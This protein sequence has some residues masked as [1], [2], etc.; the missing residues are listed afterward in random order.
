MPGSAGTLEILVAQAGKALQLLETLL[1]SGNVL[2]L[3]ASLGLRFPPQLLSQTTFTTALSK[4][5]AAAGALPSVLTKLETDISSG[6]DAAILADGVQIVQQIGTVISTLEDI[7]AQLGP[8]GSSLGMNAG[9]VAT[10]G[11]NLATSLLNYTIISYL[12][13]VQPGTVGILNI[14]GLIDYLPS[15]GVAN[16]PVHPP[17]IVRTL[18]LSRLGDL[19]KSP[20]TLAANLFDWGSPGFDGTKLVPRINTSLNL[21]GVGSRLIDT[22]PPNALTSSFVSLQANP[23]TNPPGLL[24]TLAET[25]ADGINLTLPITAMWSVDM[26]VKGTF[27]T[28]LVATVT[29][30]TRVAIKPPSGTL[31]GSLQMNLAAKAPDAN[32]PLILVGETGG[33]YVGADSFS[34]GAGLTVTWDS[35]SGTADPLIQLAVT[36]GVV[37][38]DMSDADGFL[39]DVIGGTP[40]QATFDLTGTWQPD[41]GLHIQ[42]GAQLEI[43]LPLHLDLGPVTL[44]TLYLIGGVSTTGIP[45]EASVALGVALGPIQASV[46]RVGI[47]A[48]LTFP[49]GGGNLGPADLQIKF[50]PPNGLGLDLDMGLAA[51]G[52]YITFDPVKGQYAGVLQV[53]LVD[54]IQVVVIGVLDTIMPDGSSGFSLLLIITFNFPPIQ[55]GFGFT[56]IGVGGL[57]GI[58]RTMSVSALQAGFR[59]DTL[60]LVLSPPD[61][62]ANAPQI[63]SN[64]RNFFP[65]AE[66]RYLFGPLLTLGWGTPTLLSLTLAVL[67]E[68]PDPIRIVILGLIDAGLPTED[69]ALLKLHIE[70]LGVIDFGMQTL[71]IDGSLYDSSLLIY[72]LAGDLAFRLSWG[73]NPNFVFSLGGFNPHFNT[74]GLS[75]PANMQRMSVSIGDGDNPRIS[76]NSYFAITSNSV[77]FGANVQAYAA[78]GGFSIQGYLGFDVL[79]I[80][81]PFSFE[82]DFSAS[83][84]VAYDGATLLGLTVNGSIAGPTPWHLHGEVSI[85]LLFFSVSASVDLTW[86]SS[87]Q[88][89]IPQQPVLPDLFKALQNPA[90]WSAAL[91]AGTGPTVTLTTAKP[92]STMLLVHPM[93]T[94][95]V[96]E[97]VVPLDLPITRYGNATPSDGTE[98]SISGVQINSQSETIQAVTD[99]FAP[100]Q[101]LTLSDADKLATPSFEPYDAGVQVGSSAITAGQDTVRI[102]SYDEKYIYDP[103]NLSQFSRIYQMP[104]HIHL[105]LTNQAAGFL[106]AAKNTG[107]V[108]YSAG[109]AE[110]AISVLK[111][112]QYVVTSVND[113]SLR[114]DIV[115]GSGST[116]H[117]ANAALKTY[118]SAHPEESADLQVMPL[119]EVA[120]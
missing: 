53:S 111:G 37:Y 88:A 44:P 42:G 75:V 58:N 100:G 72:S 118:L 99:Y 25:L 110:S 64:I 108:K 35:T 69:L 10:F 22:G 15:P 73:S 28:S 70:V 55:L 86:G 85:S 116:F 62:I 109:A 12:E 66:G 24:A 21:L 17:Y 74:D 46:D 78:A 114:A 11:S 26:Q 40:I 120:A 47:I 95:T 41:T 113:L 103:A 33:S 1:T 102:V 56:L 8:L 14:L 61:P 48:N 16:D 6:D 81:S 105:A 84:D 59:A 30:P 60:D 65:V 77:Q 80:I 36:K 68:V 43:D 79:I 5:A 51:G 57:G 82:F 101:F 91:P 20:S 34:F 104:A 115:S 112:A 89:T 98:F 97:T 27:S 49:S 119:H 94:L 117:Q 87:T 29:P 19:F 9:E 31:N 39:S 90:S 93:G 71:S 45:L 13:S 107:L 52:G 32:H 63:I 23:A 4:G 54:V 106:S 7:G 18:Q 96:K 50:K 3:F 76:S 83:F 92:N 2:Q 67:L 38:I